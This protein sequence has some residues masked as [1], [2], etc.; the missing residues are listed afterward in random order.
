MGDLLVR[1]GAISASQLERAV[2]EQQRSGGRMTHVLV[3][4]LQIPEELLV[5]SI[6][7]TMGV[8]PALLEQ[9]FAPADVV[10]QIGLPL[11]RSHG[12]IPESY[13]EQ[14]RLLRLAMVDPTQSEVLDLVR[15]QTG[16][17][18][19]PSVGGENAIQEAIDRLEFA[20]SDVVP[21]SGA[22][23]LDLESELGGPQ[24]DPSVDLVNPRERLQHVLR[25]QHQQARALRVLVDVLIERGAFSREEYL[26]LLKRD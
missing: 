6:A 4:R 5:Q 14:S 9:A 21:E 1:S 3:E 18:V 22:R 13:D 19:L 26:E 7:Q 2:E 12:V 10:H 15:T 20:S 11:M 24:I 16:C 8:R 23:E 17:D 25:T